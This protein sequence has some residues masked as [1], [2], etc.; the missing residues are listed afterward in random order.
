MVILTNL[1]DIDWEQWKKDRIQLEK[2]KITLDLVKE[3][4]LYNNNFLN[5]LIKSNEAK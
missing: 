1:Q 3:N 2:N 5:L 4:K